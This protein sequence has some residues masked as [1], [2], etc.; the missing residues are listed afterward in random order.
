[1]AALNPPKRVGPCGALKRV[2][3]AALAL[4]LLAGVFAPA[5]AVGEKPSKIVDETADDGIYIAPARRTQFDSSM[6]TQVIS[7][8]RAL[9]I[10]LIIAV[11]FE[12]EPTT[13][14]FARRA[15]EAAD[16]DAVII[17]GPDGVFAT[18]VSEDL[19]DNSVR[20]LN[21]A[22]AQTAPQAQA[23]TFLAEWTTDPVR[24]RPAV[25]DQTIRWVVILVAVLLGTA[26]LE[27]GVHYLKRLRRRALLRRQQ[28]AP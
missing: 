2:W 5:P 1:V 17:F 18:N 22:R 4:F 10:T 13:M 15:R 16:V 24:K 28:M 11:P 6:F 27:Q 9:G 3:L 7:D 8:A 14:A 20:A 21:A 25:I 12:A 23:E 19:E 26:F